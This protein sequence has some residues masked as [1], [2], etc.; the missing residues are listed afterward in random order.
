MEETKKALSE[1]DDIL[2]HLDRTL[3]SKIPSKMI[4][5][6]K[7]NKESSYIPKIDY[8]KSINDQ[9]LLKETRVI[10][11][12]LYRDYICSPEKKNELI[13]N[14]I[15][16]LKQVEENPVKFDYN[17]LFKEKKQEIQHVHNSEVT[18]YK[19]N[20]FQTFIMFIKKIFRKS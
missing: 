15:I 7:E 8:T 5:L 11:S 3:Y 20:I 1:I 9:E 4:Q 10:L 16:E 6:I 2:Y 14:D 17:Q 18:V 13:S 12:L 19:K